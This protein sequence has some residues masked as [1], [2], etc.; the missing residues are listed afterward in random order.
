M[1]SKGKIPVNKIS[2][3]AAIGEVLWDLF[4]DGRKL[5]GA[6]FNVVC[7]ARE[8]GAKGAM[9]SRIGDDDLGKEILAAVKEKGVD[10]RYVTADINYPTGTVSVLLDENG[11]PDF[12]IHKNVAWDFISWDD[13]MKPLAAS[14]DAV[15]FG[16]LAQRSPVTRE[17]IRRFL[18]SVPKNNCLR[19][20]DINLRQS[21]YSKDI[22]HESLE[23][24]D[25]L[26]INDDEL[27]VVSNLF[28]IKGNT[29]DIMERLINEYSLRLVALTRGS[30]GSLLVRNCET[31]DHPGLKVNVVD[32]VGAGDAFTAAMT[33]SVLKGKSLDEI[34]NNANRLAAFVC[35][36][37]GALPPIPD[38]I[39][40]LFYS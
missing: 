7:N 18:K 12:T 38:S 31:S 11:K 37:R 15:V 33:V 29:T 22:V 16:S 5:G 17:T 36:Q 4:P 6:P 24:A 39:K 19:V 14:C 3:I 20:F 21:F 27:P 10:S 1:T 32:T 28:N 9:V 34:N 2:V 8:L 25:I 40:S 35:T 26:K 13:S 30:K 23:F